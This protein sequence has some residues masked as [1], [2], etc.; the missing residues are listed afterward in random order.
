MNGSAVLLSCSAV[1]REQ[2]VVALFQ[3][4]RDDEYDEILDKEYRA[5]HFTYGEFEENEVE[6]VKLKNWCA[7]VAGR[8]VFG[9]RTSDKTRVSDRVFGTHPT[10]A[11]KRAPTRDQGFGAQA[12]SQSSMLRAPHRPGARLHHGRSHQP[13]RG[14]YAVAGFTR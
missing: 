7:K 5:N 10:S 8:D 12:A 14:H 4:A 2:D 3:A 6:L 13:D 1:A 9:G 11:M